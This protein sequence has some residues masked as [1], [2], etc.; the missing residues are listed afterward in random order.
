M[1]RLGVVDD[2]A[3][4]T[5]TYETSIPMPAT[6]LSVYAAVKIAMKRAREDGLTGVVQRASVH[7]GTTLQKP[8][9]AFSTYLVDDGPALVVTIFPPAAKT[10]VWELD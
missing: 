9:K 4:T 2:R 3:D 7:W 8:D 1:M 10:D 6:G 5:V